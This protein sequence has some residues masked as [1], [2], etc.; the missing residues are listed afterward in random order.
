MEGARFL[1]VAVACGRWVA[2]R[3]AGRRAERK[4]A[5]PVVA[6]AARRGPAALLPAV[7]NGGANCLIGFP[8]RML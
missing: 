8:K 3:N 6:V 7:Q 1:G 2:G 4:Q 5:A